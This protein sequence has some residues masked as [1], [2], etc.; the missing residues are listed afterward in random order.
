MERNT[1]E[2]VRQC[3]RFVPGHHPISPKEMLTALAETISADASSDSYGNGEIITNFEKYHVCDANQAFMGIE[4]HQAVFDAIAKQDSTLAK[5]KMK[6]H[7]K[8]LYQYCY[9]T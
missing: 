2:I 7:F 6:E 3:T 5:A 4:E 8:A 1:K 9:H